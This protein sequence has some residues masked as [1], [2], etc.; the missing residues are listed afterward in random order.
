TVPSE[1]LALNDASLS[2]DAWSVET[3]Q[4]SRCLFAQAHSDAALG[5]PGEMLRSPFVPLD[6]QAREEKSPVARAKRAMAGVANAT[7]M[8][9][10]ADSPATC[11]RLFVTDRSAWVLPPALEGIRGLIEQ[12]PKWG[13]TRLLSFGLAGAHGENFIREPEGAPNVPTGM[14]A[15]G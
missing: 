15:Q 9:C 10:D 4:F 2:K 3:G 6:P 7:R 8:A 13:Q 5:R 11:P 12:A 14:L 1:L